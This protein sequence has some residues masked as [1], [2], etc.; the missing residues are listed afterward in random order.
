MLNNKL[1]VFEG[2][3][4]SYG[5]GIGPYRAIGLY[6]AVLDTKIVFFI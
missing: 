3:I 1:K 2:P 5:P 4:R 6:R